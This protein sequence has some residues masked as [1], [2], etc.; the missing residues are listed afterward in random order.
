[1]PG[2]VTMRFASGLQ[3]IPRAEIAKAE[4]LKDGTADGVAKGI[5][6]GLLC[7]G[8]MTLRQ[9]LG[10]IAMMGA[11]GYLIDASISNHELIYRAAGNAPAKTVAFRIRF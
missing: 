11:I 3:S 10:G 7:V 2:G 8:D 6:V 1:M 5:L 4:R 9:Y